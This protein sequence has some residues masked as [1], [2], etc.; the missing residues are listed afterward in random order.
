MVMP[1]AMDDMLSGQL[2]GPAGEVVGKESAAVEAFEEPGIGMVGMEGVEL[3]E[4]GADAP[5]VEAGLADDASASTLVPSN[6]NNAT[7]TDARAT[8]RW[9]AGAADGVNTMRAAAAS[10]V[11]VS[12][13]T[14]SI[15]SQPV[16][17]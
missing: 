6:D 1:A 17:M 16:T 3:D 11:V 8:A 5:A 15:V 2:M 4:V 10:I 13:P 14:R 9:R 7:G 12:K